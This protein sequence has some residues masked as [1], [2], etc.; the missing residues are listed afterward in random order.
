MP[1]KCWNG[2]S[3]TFSLS[4]VPWLPTLPTQGFQTVKASA[5]R[6]HREHMVLV[7]DIKLVR[8]YTTLK[9]RE[10]MQKMVRWRLSTSFPTFR[11]S[12]TLSILSDRTKM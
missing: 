3:W 12:N 7:S 5:T 2:W 1:K 4:Q 9:G 11:T 10:A 8:T 6:F